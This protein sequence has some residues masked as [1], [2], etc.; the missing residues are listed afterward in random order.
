MNVDDERRRLSATWVNFIAAAFVSGGAIA[1]IAVSSA[2]LQLRW[3]HLAIGGVSLLAG[4]LTHLVARA[5][6]RGP[7]SVKVDKEQHQDDPV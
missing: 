7:G 1:P 4:V 3:Q 2:S 5:V 6:L